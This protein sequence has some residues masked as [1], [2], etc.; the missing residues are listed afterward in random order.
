MILTVK[1]FAIALWVLIGIPIIIIAFNALINDG[2]PTPKEKQSFFSYLWN[3]KYIFMTPLITTI[4]AIIITYKETG[5][6]TSSV[7][8]WRIFGSIAII[9]I[10]LSVKYYRTRH[11]ASMPLN[12][13]SEHQS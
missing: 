3:S 7:I 11:I 9:M 6:I 13:E 8:F 4:S 1:H 5:I 2:M 12:K 10:F